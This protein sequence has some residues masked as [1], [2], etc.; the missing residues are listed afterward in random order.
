MDLGARGIFGVPYF[1][2]HNW[3]SSIRHFVKV[4]EDYANLKPLKNPKK[5]E[6]ADIVFEDSAGKLTAILIDNGYLDSAVWKN[7]KPKYYIE[8]KT[9]RKECATKFFMSKSQ[10]KRVSYRYEYGFI[11]N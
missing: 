6:E 9:T 5:R 11:Q 8:V 2:R 3:E 7:A 4:H 1:G 10:Y